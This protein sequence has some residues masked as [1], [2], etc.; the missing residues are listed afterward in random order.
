MLG[1]MKSISFITTPLFMFL[2]DL[3]THCKIVPDTNWFDLCCFPMETQ[4][5]LC[6]GS[7]FLNYMSD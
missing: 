1:L 2:L 3:L 7:Y 4:R 5:K 6:L